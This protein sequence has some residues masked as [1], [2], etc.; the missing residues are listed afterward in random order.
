MTTSVY[1]LGVRTLGSSGV[2]SGERM[3]VPEGQP[4]HSTAGK[5]GRETVKRRV[6]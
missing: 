4:R 5:S 1:P 3:M 6:P 2:G